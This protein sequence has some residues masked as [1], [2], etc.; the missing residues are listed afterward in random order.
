MRRLTMIAASLALTAAAPSPALAALKPGASAPDFTTTAAK[1]GNTFG[2][3]LSKQLKK[4]PV[5]LYFFPAAF[6]SGCTVEANQFAEATDEFAKYGATVIGLSADPIDKLTKFST[7]E[8][9]SKFAVAMASP[10]TIA[11]YDAKLIFG[12]SNRTSYF[13]TP[14]GKITA[15][16]SDLDYRQH[17]PEML[18]AAKAWA[19]TKK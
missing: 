13:I 4:G 15:V 6:T 17:V 12:K 2:F 7:S 11:A 16:H 14:Q 5:V 10:T 9:R 1:A 3:S 8:C 18:K 19:G